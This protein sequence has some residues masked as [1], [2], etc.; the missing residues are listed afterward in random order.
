MGEYSEQVKEAMEH[1]N[2]DCIDCL[3]APHAW[4]MD[5]RQ[6]VTEPRER[7]EKRI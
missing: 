2:Q 5:C 1:L 7:K 4:I 6:C 3:N